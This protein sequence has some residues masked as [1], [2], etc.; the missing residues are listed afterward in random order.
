MADKKTIIDNLPVGKANAISMSN[1]KDV[2]GMQ[3]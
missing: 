3:T 1:L 2:L